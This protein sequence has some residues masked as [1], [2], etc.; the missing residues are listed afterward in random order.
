MARSLSTRHWSDANS[1]KKERARSERKA[2]HKAREP[3][4]G[5]RLQLKD[6]DTKRDNRAIVTRH[7]QRRGRGG[8]PTAGGYYDERLS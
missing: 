2:N 6:R 5:F 8:K 3:P 1:E 7:W 4:K